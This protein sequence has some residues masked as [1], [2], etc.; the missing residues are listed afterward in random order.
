[1]SLA[2]DADKAARS[3]SAAMDPRTLF[4][5]LVGAAACAGAAFWP[6]MMRDGDTWWHLKAGEW[7]IANRAVPHA[8]PFS[9][10]MLGHPWVA[11]EWLSEVLM[12]SAF[13]AG[14]WAGLALL[15]GLCFGATMAVLARRLALSMGDAV[16]ALV[17][18][19]AAWLLAPYLT[20]RPHL[21]ALPLVAFWADRLVAARE[22]G[23]APPLVIAL[24]MTAWANMHGGFI[25]GLALIAPFALEAVIA[26]PMGG[27]LFAARA[28]A[29]FAAASLVA[30][31][32]TPFFVRG[33]LFPFQLASMHALARI[34][35]WQAPNL[36]AFAFLPA[37]MLA[38]LAL[39]LMTPQR[40][41]AIRTA[42]LVA[43]MA[44]TA[45]H[46]RHEALLAI[47]GAMILAP[48]IGALT[49]RDETA[50]EPI[51]RSAWAFALPMVVAV[52]AARLLHPIARADDAVSPV[53]ALA[54]VPADVRARRVLND[55]DFGG[56]LIAQGVAPYIDGRT[57]LYGDAFIA[58]FVGLADAP[59]ALH[60]ELDRDSIGW[61]IFKAD[62]KIVPLLDKEP[63]WR[64]LFT[65]D[66]VVVHV[67]ESA[68][69]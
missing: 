41:G 64:R 10:S 50:A 62:R 21:L 20:A 32:A 36:G 55:Y 4:A 11:H 22:A 43:L 69:R 42:L 1:M 8:D 14:G 12:A 25:F 37:T 53:S 18:L 6:G 59:Q 46:V 39:A 13:R 63:G 29:A 54:A 45:A 38:I 19:A 66:A 31:L 17:L 15:G 9:S 67:R 28:W 24:A 7:I 52:A 33:L 68:V 30:A 27:R 3:P 35:E 40:L 58:A 49:K 44:Q 51:A 61:T 56:Y 65:S 60:A 2:A 34:G 23:R 26:A 16:A 47:V 57:D 48:M 5:P